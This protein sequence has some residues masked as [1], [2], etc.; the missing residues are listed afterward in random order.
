MKK[1]LESMLSTS[2]IE[3]FKCNMKK[4][5]MEKW[6]KALRSG[7]F[8]QTQHVLHDNNGYCCLGVLCELAPNTEFSQKTA[9]DTGGFLIEGTEVEEEV[10]ET[11]SS[12]L[13]PSVM[14]WAGMFS[15]TGGPQGWQKES[16]AS[17]NDKG[18][19]FT[20]IADIIEKNYKIF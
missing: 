5:I 9:G 8:E 14:N 1:T 18:K 7:K 3:R 20:E 2:E 6:V 12:V 10:E 17:M 13:P 16:L 11:Y 15:C 19:S 4:A